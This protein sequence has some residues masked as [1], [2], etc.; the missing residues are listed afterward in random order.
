MMEERARLHSLDALR[1][2]DM[3]WIMGLA[4]VVM[5]FCRFWPGGEGLWLFRQMRHAAWE[6]FTFYD[7]IFPLFLFMAG[8]SFPFSYASQ[9]R[10]GFSSARI[11]LKMLKRLLLLILLSMVQCGILQFDPEKYRYVSVL[12]RIGMSWFVAALIYVHFRPKVRI[13]A[14]IAVV[15]GYWALLMFCK[16][17]L[18]AADASPCAASGNIVDWLDRFLSLRAWFGRDPFEVRDVP[19]AFFQMPL[20]LL[21]MFAGDVVRN[22]RLAPQR[23]TIMLLAGGVLLALFGIALSFA[24]CPIVKNLTTPSFMLLSG[25]LCLMLFSA[26]YWIIDVK[27][28]VAWSYP[29]RVIG[30]NAI[31]AYLMQTII[32]FGAISR[33]FFGGVA[34][35]FP[36]PDFVL[37]L[38]YC[39]VCWLF[40]WFL[41]RHKV[42]LKA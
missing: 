10:R 31:V 28:H 26:F 34:S 17:P 19:L 37:A 3:I 22:E 2:F 38:G 30:M 36:Q 32:P 8:M 42:Y 16:S 25:G 27:G 35:L 40:L 23:R 9:V 13:A 18:A 39:L 29:L 24:G 12:Q 14:A 5:C 7:L 41:H 21:G 6:G 15:A 33:F 1:G 4:S 20:A 11:H